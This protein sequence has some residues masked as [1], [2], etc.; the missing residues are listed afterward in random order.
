[1][2]APR[3]GFL[4]PKRIER[5][6]HRRAI[7]RRIAGE[8]NLD[9]VEIGRAL[10]YTRR[11]WQDIMTDGNPHGLRLEDAAILGEVLGSDALL[12]EL[13]RVSGFRLVRELD[14]DASAADVAGALADQLR[15][16]ARVAKVGGAALED[17][18]VD[19]VE[20]K[21]I[22]AAVADAVRALNELQASVTPSLTDTTLSFR[23][24][25]R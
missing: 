24:S 2:K 16:A 25:G 12:E 10:G 11:R 13:A 6:N 4:S 19:A 14:V 20:A 1:M 3:T 17:G 23:R 21:A 7:I 18:R 22:T 9:Q 15:H 8:K 5:S